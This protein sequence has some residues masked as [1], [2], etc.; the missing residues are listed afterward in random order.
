M[1]GTENATV[2]ATET[3][4]ESETTKAHLTSRVATKRAAAPLKMRPKRA[5]RATS[6]I[7]RGAD[8]HRRHTDPP[9]LQSQEAGLDRPSTEMT[10]THRNRKFV[11]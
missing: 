2:I 5:A 7:E 4:I 9:K 11:N 8:R 3:G 1:S 10:D 6:A